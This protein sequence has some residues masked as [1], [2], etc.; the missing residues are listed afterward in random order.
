MKRATLGLFILFLLSSCQ[1]HPDQRKLI[2][3]NG[4]W[5]ITKTDTF[6]I[7]PQKFESKVPVPGLVDLAKPALDTSR[8]YKNDTYWY[9]TSFTIGQDYPDLIKLKIGK[10]RYHA[11]IYLNNKYVGEHLY[12]FTSALFDIR[13]FLNPAG[14]KNELL[15]GVGAVNNMPDT[16]IWGSDFEKLTYIP[17]IYDDVTLI[18]SGSPF[19]SNIQTVPL[20]EEKKVRIVA[21][22]DNPVSDKK[23]SLS[24]MIK[25]L[26]T[27]KTVAKGKGKSK[28]FE[29]SIP[30]CQ[31][32]TPESPVLYELTLSTGADE[33]RV[34]FGMRSFS[35]DPKTGRALLNNKPYFMRGTNV[36]IFR[37]FEDPDRGLLPWNK[38]WVT[39]LHEQ[40]KS[41]N[42]NSIRYCI[43]L[44]PECWYDIADSLG[45]LLQNE[46]PVWTGGREG[47][48]RIYPGVTS[49][50]LANEYRAWLPEHWN[51]PSVV[52]WD[53]QN[54]SVTE[55]IGEAINKVRGMDLSNRPWENGWSA[56]QSETD[57]MESHPYLFG[58]YRRGQPPSPRGPMADFFVHIQVPGN[59]AQ[60]N[61]PRE[62]RSRY[63]NPIII[64]EYAWIWL[65]R[66]GSPT[67]LTD[68][69]YEVA[70]GP[71]LT[72]D[73]R[74]YL[75]TRHLGMLTEYWRANRFCAG[76]L[77]F[78]G[79]G[80]SRPVEPRGQT[81]D[82]FIDIKNLVYEP[83]FVKYVKPAFNPVGLMI[84]FWDRSLQSGRSGITLGIEVYTIN[85]LDIP[86]SGPITL[87]LRPDSGAVS[88]QIKEI[89]IP[90]YERLITTFPLDIHSGPGKYWLEA[91][92]NYQGE[93][94]KSIREFTVEQAPPPER[95]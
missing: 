29:V 81:S 66:D 2:S 25:E 77:H 54:E 27:G 92:I 69:V 79:L 60:T 10:V 9:K 58:R 3:L 16:V 7:M 75:Y 93:S 88:T 44:P 65:N 17:G 61:F 13:E 31:L 85:D 86:W 12:C 90:A 57:P 89:E 37:F 42:W 33:K 36:C 35:F 55:I 59:S 76:V 83:L 5:E 39:K 46:Y 20:I 21:D 73:E 51:H 82:N 8:L 71:D 6:A 70:F 45:I 47:F 48:S 52:I 87:T 30:G 34:R 64:N 84:D 62:D 74:V 94:I 67:T 40:F 80:Y 56:P 26:K 32:W 95:R 19:I 24:Y 63:P 49:E 43:G 22:I 91:E 72:R 23:I 4:E 11:R 15:I 78:C 41:M 38:V 68:R 28:D 53:A 18:L 14:E 50:H 1:Q